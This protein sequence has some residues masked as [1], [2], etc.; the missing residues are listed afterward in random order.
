MNKVAY[1]ILKDSFV[2]D[3][4]YPLNILKNFHPEIYEKEAKKYEGRE[5]LLEAR[6]PILNCLWNDVVQFSC[7]DPR[8]TFE[9]VKSYNPA[10]IG[11]KIKVF[12]LDLNKV[13]P[14]FSC[15]FMPKDTPIKYEHFEDQYQ[16]FKL[17][18]F[19]N[20]NE[21]PQE[22]I[23]RW[24]RDLEK[25]KPLFLWSATLHFMYKGNVPLEWGDTFEFVV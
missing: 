1:H 21:L 9:A 14:E 8:I 25:N 10:Y 15:L 11:R 24:N 6:N 12:T 20:L 23:A 7:L 5:K 13:A 18:N 22:Q 4:I 16:V 17:E 3:S 2:G 19:Q